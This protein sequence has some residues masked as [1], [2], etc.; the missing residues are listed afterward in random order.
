MDNAVFTGLKGSDY[1]LG[2]DKTENLLKNELKS[3]EKRL[4]DIG[5][6]EKMRPE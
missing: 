3:V 2:F 1:I 4:R 5:F 6:Q